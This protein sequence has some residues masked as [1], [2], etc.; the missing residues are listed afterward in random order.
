M[1]YN[2]RRGEVVN[3]LGMGATVPIRVDGLGAPIVL[4]I[5]VGVIDNFIILYV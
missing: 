1:P 2:G 5:W 4:R 3:S